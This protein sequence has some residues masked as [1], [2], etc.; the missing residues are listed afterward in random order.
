MKKYDIKDVN[1]TRFMANSAQTNFNVVKKVFRSE[2][3]TKSMTK[4]EKTCQF[5]WSQIFDPY[6]K[7]LIKVEL[8]EIHKQFC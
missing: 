1:F 2:N 8:Q 3:K 4:T 6:I 7:Q 5:H